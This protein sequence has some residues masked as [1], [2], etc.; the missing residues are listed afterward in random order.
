M[1]SAHWSALV[2]RHFAF[3]TWR[4]S[5]DLS[6]C[7]HSSVARRSAQSVRSPTYQ[8]PSAI[9]T[10]ARTQ[11]SLIRASSSSCCTQNLPSFCTRSMKART[12]AHSSHRSEARRLARLHTRA[13]APAY[14]QCM[15]AV[16]CTC[17]PCF[18]AMADAPTSTRSRSSTTRRATGSATR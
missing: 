8:L 18:G 10:C 9:S 3:A 6:S 11:P 17:C 7:W 5:V 14:T 1:K 15:H 16:L 12:S 13:L 2:V 4:S